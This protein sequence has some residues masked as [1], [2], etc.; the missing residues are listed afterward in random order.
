MPL[1]VRVRG[2]RRL[3]MG[4]YWVVA[5]G[6]RAWAWDPDGVVTGRLLENRQ[7]ERTLFAALQVYRVKMTSDSVRS[8]VE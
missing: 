5:D 7:W 3:G 1:R 6:A 8:A 2:P 4:G